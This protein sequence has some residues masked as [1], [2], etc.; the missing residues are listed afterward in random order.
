MET[1]LKRQEEAFL[2]FGE[3]IRESDEYLCLRYGRA[4]LNDKGE[5]KFLIKDVQNKFFSATELEEAA[6]FA[7]K[8]SDQ[9]NDVFAGI[10]ARKFGGTK[11]D[12][13]IRC[14]LAY[15]DVDAPGASARLEELPPPSF[16]NTS[17]G[18]Y[19]DGTEKT[20]V[21]WVLEEAAS[22]ADLERITKPLSQ[23]L[24]QGVEHVFDAAHILRVPGTWYFKHAD[25][26]DRMT[27]TVS[28][29]GATYG[30]DEIYEPDPIAAP[31]NLRRDY[32]ETYGEGEDRGNYLCAVGGTL[33]RLYLD[34][35]YAYGYLLAHNETFCDPPAAESHVKNAHAYL[36]QDRR[37]GD[38]MDYGSG[39]DTLLAIM[40]HLRSDLYDEKAL[41]VITAFNDMLRPPVSDEELVRIYE[42]HIAADEEEDHSKTEK[43]AKAKSQASLLVE[44][45]GGDL[46]HTPDQTAYV[47]ML[48]D[49]HRKT[50]A[51]RSRAF[52]MWLVYQFDLK[53]GNSPGAQAIA[54]ALT[55]LEAKAV[56]ASQHEV[57]VRLAEYDGDIYLDLGDEDWT[58]IRITPDSWD[59]IT[60]PPVYFRRPKSTLPLPMPV[61][62]GS[63]DDLRGLVNV[64]DDDDWMLFVAILLGALHPRGPFPVLASF[65]EQGSA[66][67][68]ATRIYR[69]LVDPSLVEL[70]ALP[71]TTHD[72]AIMARGSWILP[73]DN[74]SSLSSDLS[75]ALCRMS[76]GGGFGTRTLYSDDEE[77]VFGERRPIALNGITEFV[78]RPDLLNRAIMLCHPSIPDDER[79]TEAEF[80]ELLEYV[81]PGV[82]GALLDV[83]AVGLA[84]LPDV[85]LDTLPRMADF[86][87]WIVACAPALGWDE[88]AFL[89]AYEA[90]R[91]AAN[92][93]VL[94]NSPI[95]SHIVTLAEHGGFR[96]NQK[97]L[98]ICV[99]DLALDAGCDVS[100]HAFFPQTPQM[101][102]RALSRIVTNLRDTGVR[103]DPPDKNDHKRTLTIHPTNGSSANGP[104]RTKSS[105]K[106]STPHIASTGP[107]KET[108]V[109]KTTSSQS[110]GNGHLSD[111]RA[112]EMITSRPEFVA[113]NS[114]APSA[115]TIEE[116]FAQL[117]ERY[118]KSP[119]T[120]NST[121]EGAVQGS[122]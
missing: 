66:K 9:G 36:V 115:V 108:P 10:A 53:M 80:D 101:M 87:L 57:H 112:E 62:G 39:T 91:E 96:G 85:H 113:Y 58:V 79:M 33:K 76:T 72:L 52:R 109:P 32:G 40:R 43:K 82:L 69:R 8:K 46:F 4:G 25:T 93:T 42:A 37:N 26:K 116:R 21:C 106:S 7:I 61:R 103:V 54:D 105:T 78:T 5:R 97:Q 55:S 24:A 6:A 63:V 86:A 119:N 56:H 68:S 114:S 59:A 47:S 110:N 120:S 27:F 60:N 94:D 70:R 2:F 89:S 107:S 22:T 100:K 71:R 29:T 50:W 1:A 67:S 23:F 44:M 111:E 28:H 19:D 118:V 12:G 34:P 16:S 35:D 3:I 98:L 75:D 30:Y 90:N 65:G 99:R 13:I 73:F 83:V 48:I 64:A 95:A 51:I 77:M 117:R 14:H 74:C 104:G 11:K 38:T 15:A 92:D 49:G 20:H 17:G 45:V 81:R 41:E 84:N 88:E 102:G 31:T 18:L 122:D 121:K